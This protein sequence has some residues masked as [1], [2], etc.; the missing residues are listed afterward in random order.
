VNRSDAPQ[1]A[2]GA[3]S[4]TEDQ[5]RLAYGRTFAVPGSVPVIFRG[6]TPQG[7]PLINLASDPPSFGTLVWQ[8]TR[9]DA[10][11]AAIQLRYADRTNAAD[12]EPTETETA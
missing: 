7:W 4:L 3:H 9:A 6:F 1:T 10:L 8:D 2:P 5:H 11:V 12:N